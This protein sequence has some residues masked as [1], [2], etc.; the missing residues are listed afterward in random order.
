MITFFQYEIDI[1]R[2]LLNKI[3]GVLDFR[4]ENSFWGRKPFCIVLVLLYRSFIKPEVYVKELTDVGFEHIPGGPERAARVARAQAARRLGS[5]IPPPYPNG[6]FSVAE[7]G[8][9]T[10]GGV[11]AVDALGQNLCVY[12]GED[13]VARCVDAYC[14]HLGAH[15]AIH[16][17]VSGDCI[18]C[19]FHKWRFGADGVLVSVPGI[20]TVPKGV[21]IKTWTVAEAEG[22]IW[23]WHDAEGRPPLW[24]LSD[25]PELK[26]YSY[27]GQNRFTVNCHIQEI[28]ENGADVAHLNAVHATSVLTKPF[29]NHPSLQ[30]FI[31]MFTCY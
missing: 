28:P 27:R 12:R 14:P 1:T 17:A 11:L 24:D 7:S 20:E 22:A 19:P 2:L 5:R 10:A 3:C 6:W 25:P 4:R 16:G 21:S 31:G 13:G 30:N 8:N 9:V 23:I 26:T 18:E 29:G 15:L